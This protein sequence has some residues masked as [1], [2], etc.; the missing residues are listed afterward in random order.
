MPSSAKVRKIR[1]DKGKTRQ[2]KDDYLKSHRYVYTCSKCNSEFISTKNSKKIHCKAC[3]K[4]LKS[5]QKFTGIEGIDYIICPVCK[6]RCDSLTVNHVKLHGFESIKDF[7]IE[8]N[9]KYSKC[10]TRREKVS[11]EN[12]PGYR[13]NGKF[14]AWSKNFKNG[15]DEERH[16]ANNKNISQIRKDNP[17]KNPF[18]LEFWKAKANGDVGLAKEMYLKFQS[19]DLGWFI[20]KYGEIEGTIQHKAKIEKWIDALNAK[21]IEE[22]ADINRRKVR[23]SFRAFSKIEL[24]LY[25]TLLD[26]F[27]SLIS[28]FVICIE[29]DGKKKS[30]VYDMCFENKII[31]FYGDYW[32]ANPKKYPVTFFNKTCK[33]N[34]NQIHQRDLLKRQQAESMGYSVLIVWEND[35]ITN[36][37]ET[38]EQCLTFLKL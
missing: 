11:G 24:E 2:N 34:F 33:M 8:H 32:H 10:T 16:L 9:L 37:Q 21:S 3:I 13:H 38:I 30:H 26:N 18:N 35:Y 22:M 5:E 25:N 23:K 17:D 31:E 29:K 20:D 12:N 15:Y 27:Q 19:K 6:V 1:S 28:Q 7:L 14:S 36:K 4:I